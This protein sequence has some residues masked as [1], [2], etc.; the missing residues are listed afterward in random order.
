MGSIHKF[1]LNGKKLVFDVESGALHEFDAAAWRALDLIEAGLDEA[2]AVEAMRPEF[3]AEAAA[4]ALAEIKKLK[5]EGLLWSEPRR[6]AG[7]AAPRVKAL[8]LF[9]S[10]DC[11]LSCRY[12]FV[13][14]GLRPPARK[15]MS[16]AV[17]RAAIDFLIKVSGPRA[18]CEVDFFGGEPLLNFSALQG[19][20]AYARRAFAAAGKEIAFTVTSNGLLLSPAVGDYLEREGFYTILSLDGRAEVHDRMRRRPGGGGSYS[21]VLPRL[22]AYTERQPAGGYYV[23]GTYTRHNKDFTRDVEHLYAQGFCYIS[24]EPVVAAPGVD[25]ALRESDLPELEREYEKLAAFYLQCRAAGD[26]FQ[27]FHFAIDL[28]QGP[29]LEK[30]LSGCGAGL[31]YLA[32]TADGSIYPCHQ[33]AGRPELCMGNVLEPESFNPELPP[34]FVPAGPLQGRC[35]ECWARYF[36]GGGCRAASYLNGTPGE[37]YPLECA[38]QRKRL[39]CALYLHAAA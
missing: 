27:F 28:E 26:P 12:C 37:P 4:G 18:H 24:L 22:R 3:G 11:N 8:C 14:G 5:D 33:L 30:R 25:Y 13:E 6:P 21:A 9:L 15:H 34:T 10:E 39:E 1:T 2:A 36:C 35:R 31:E 38:L 17:G 23:R 16:E 20:T 29:C 19:I 32:V 7:G